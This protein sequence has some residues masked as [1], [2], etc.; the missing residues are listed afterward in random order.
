MGG[1]AVQDKPAGM[2][3]GF[4]TI[5]ACSTLV[6]LPPGCDEMVVDVYRMKKKSSSSPGLPDS[7]PMER[8]SG[9]S[10]GRPCSRLPQP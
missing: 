3:E 2:R 1:A 9:R 7:N 4:Q 6:K 8:F 5:R 10:V